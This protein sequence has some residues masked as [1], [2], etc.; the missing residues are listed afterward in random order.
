MKTVTSMLT[1]VRI[2]AFIALSI[3]LW[4]CTDHEMETT[5]FQLDGTSVAEWKGY[6]KTGYFNEGSIAVKSE[7][8]VIRDGKVQSGSF[9][10]PV[11]SIINFNLPTDEVKHQLVHHL[12]S[13]D[14]FNMVLHPNV[15]F[16]I[17]SVAP[18][19]G[20]GENVVPGANYQVTGILTL[21]G[22]SNVIIF[23]AKIDV[24][25][26]S[27]KLDGLAPFDRTLF[28]MNYATEPNLPDDAA[29][30]PVID[31]HLKLSGKRK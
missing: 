19:S 5:Q 10:I 12:Q 15:T 25:G 8:L 3:T 29:I 9:T 2:I 24:I 6:L 1:K 27:F 20:T 30:K 7:S 13:P 21:L 11:S 23:P 4:N 22:K 28:G 17:S 26:D 31:V 16:E 18:F 14:F